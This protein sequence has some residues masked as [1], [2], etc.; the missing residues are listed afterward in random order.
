MKILVVS[1]THGRI[2]NVVKYIVENKIKHMIHLGDCIDDAE[3][4]Q[5]KTDIDLYYI[6]GNCD[7]YSVSVPEEL[8][9]SFGNKR[10][11][12][13][14]GHK[15]GVKYTMDKLQKKARDTEVDIVLFG[16]THALMMEEVDGII[17]FNPGSPS[18]PRTNKDKTIGILEI[19]EEQLYYYYE[20]L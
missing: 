6:R 5:E 16:H 13:T 7:F 1:D 15:Y 12:C 2:D 17:Y 14:H 9:L 10:I 4:I 20:P 3:K 19:E 11:L 18:L 8:I